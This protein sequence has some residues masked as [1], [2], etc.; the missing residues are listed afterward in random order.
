[1]PIVSEI[2]NQLQGLGSISFE[3]A[4][5]TLGIAAIAAGVAIPA[6]LA[7][8]DYFRNPR[9]TEEPLVGD[10]ESAEKAL[11][12]EGKQGKINSVWSRWGKWA[13]LGM[14]VSV[15]S[16]QA[17]QPTI[18]FEKSVP[19][20]QVMHVIDVSESMQLTSDMVGNE[21]RFAAVAS[22]L[23]GA[24]NTFPTDLNAGIIQFGQDTKLTTPLSTDRVALQAGL[25]VNQVSSNGSN[26]ESALS[27]AADVSANNANT[28]NDAIMVYTDGTI[29]NR[30]AT[31]ETLTEIAQTGTE[32][33]IVMPGTVDGNFVRTEYDINPTPSGVKTAGF[34]LIDK[35]FENVQVFTADTATDIQN[36]ISE[37]TTQQ[38]IQT[39]TRSTNIFLYV[40]SAI[41]AFGA[42][43]GMRK[44]WKRKN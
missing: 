35:E 26:L 38:T 28:G 9:T 27:L 33:V 13:V 11:D 24:S 42:F 22:S 20:S 10:I 19:D 7:A 40:G 34:D 25:V 31:I 36:I 15:A 32:I 14:G 12:A 1:M 37:Q 29:E 41:A 39:A 30:E 4:K 23:L 8:A 18:E 43:L 16:I 3:D 5:N 17:L 21:T 44:D 6:S 2:I